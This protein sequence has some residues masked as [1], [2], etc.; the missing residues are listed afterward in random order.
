MLVH[1]ACRR[2]RVRHPLRGAVERRLPVAAHGARRAH[3]GG[4]AHTRGPV[5]AIR[6]SEDSHLPA[7]PGPHA[8]RRANVP[9]V[10][11]ERP[12]GPRAA[13]AATRRDWRARP[14][15][16]TAPNHVW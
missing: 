2:A 4:D 9:A 13:T 10:A 7:S 5:S 16:P 12:P 14:L 1:A 11:T 6:V 8:E 15:P 3:G